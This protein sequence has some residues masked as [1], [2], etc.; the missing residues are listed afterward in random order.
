MLPRAR[1]YPADVATAG[2][3][4][5]TSSTASGLTLATCVASGVVGLGWC[6]YGVIDAVLLFG[7]YHGGF[8][9]PWGLLLFIT[10]GLGTFGLLACAAVIGLSL[11]R[12]ET[13]NR[14]ALLAC[15]I[16][17]LAAGGAEILSEYGNLYHAVPSTIEGWGLISMF[18]RTAVGP[19]ACSALAGLAWWRS[20]AG[21]PAA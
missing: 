6:I 10:E 2:E 14:V 16:S 15:A 7:M 8:A 11:R 3:R 4:E 9:R 19:F 17:G 12:S 20:G 13:G 1:G 21:R 5:T 18:F